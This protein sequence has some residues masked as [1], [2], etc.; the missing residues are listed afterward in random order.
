MALMPI[1][2]IRIDRGFEKRLPSPQGKELEGLVEDIRAHGVIVDL[3]VTKDGLL[4]DGHRRLNAAK[5]AGLS[6]VPVKK[7]DIGGED[8]W[9]E[10]VAIATNLFRRHLNEAQ[11]ANLGSSLLRLER[12]K[13]RKRQVEGGRKGASIAGKGRRKEQALGNGSPEPKCDVDR[14]TERVANA[15]GISRKT[16]ERVETVKREDPEL[17]K[18]MLEGRISVA[19]AYRILK[20]DAGEK[21]PQK[22]APEE[23]AAGLIQNLA[24]VLRRYRTVYMDLSVVHE[25]VTGTVTLK[26]EKLSRLPLGKLGHSEGCHYWV[27]APWPVIRDGVP[28]RLFRAWGLEWVGELVWDRKAWGVGK[29]FRNRTEILILAVSGDPPLFRGVDP[30]VQVRKSGRSE[31]P[32]RFYELIEELSPGPRI[33]LFT[34]NPREGWD[35][36]GG[37]V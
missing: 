15:V 2:E 35:R 13:A 27:W 1:D 10:S 37:D 28:H 31:K 23:P 33:E 8:G 17:A 5:K 25:D 4:L 29:W 7:I 6:R 24:D 30:L 3:L 19:A 26:E 36:W 34:Y 16:F 11:R 14:A 12:Q 22:G 21:R 9:E 32:K 20:S 18:R